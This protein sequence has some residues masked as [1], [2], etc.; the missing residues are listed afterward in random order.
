MLRMD[1]NTKNEALLS[2]EKEL[3]ELKFRMLDLEM[4]NEA[5]V[6]LEEQTNMTRCQL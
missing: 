5:L 2:A 4:R 6:K 3:L 1:L